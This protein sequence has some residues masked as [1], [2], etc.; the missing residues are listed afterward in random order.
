MEWAQDIAPS[1]KAETFEQPITNAPM[2]QDSEQDTHYPLGAARAQ[3]HENYIIAQTQN[4]MVI[5]DQHAAHERLVYERLKE[6]KA[7]QEIIKQGL[8][9]PEIV[10][11][12]ENDAERLLMHQE[13]LA[14]M[15]LEI[16]AFGAG[17]I[18]VQ[19]YPA[20]LGQKP[21]LNAL[22]HKLADEVT[23]H[24]TAQGLEERLNAILSTM[25]CHGSIRSGGA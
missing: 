18:A 13:N 25:A 21:K 5:V 20:L 7:Q 22:I 19:A 9:T 3:I 1:A 2:P 16:D 12:D 8:L 23:L 10:E 24:E 17:A 15:G 11:L 6:Q 4:G 14:Q